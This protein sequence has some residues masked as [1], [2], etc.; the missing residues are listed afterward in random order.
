MVGGLIDMSVIVPKDILKF[1]LLLVFLCYTAQNQISILS[2]Q[3]NVTKTVHL[4][5]KEHFL[6]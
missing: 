2:Y 1:D 5:L 4:I 3:T 6:R